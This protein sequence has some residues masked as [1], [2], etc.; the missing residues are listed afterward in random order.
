MTGASTKPRPHARRTSGAARPAGKR[1]RQGGSPV[2]G[3]TSRR[4]D[5][6]SASATSLG[7]RRGAF[8]GGP[9]RCGWVAL[10]GPPN[11]GKSTLLNAMLGQKVSIVTPRPQTTRNQIVGILTDPDAQIIFMDTPG[12]AQVR[13]R[14]SKAMVQ[15]AWQSLAQADAIVLLLDAELYIRKPEFLDNDTAALGEAL[16]Q[17]ERPLVVCVNKIDLFS[18]KSR[19]LPLLTRLHEMWPRAEIYPTSALTRDGLVE[20]VR[21]LKGLLP[22]G[23]A[24]FPEDQLSTAPVRFMAA[25]IV[26]EKLF[27]HLQQEVPYAVAVDIEAWEEDAQTG[28][29]LIHAAIH[30]A[31]PSHKAMVIG[32]GGAMIKEIGTE[33]RK[34]IEALLGCKVRLELWVK[35][36]EHWSE[37]VQFLQEMGLIQE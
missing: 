8:L 35:V 26:R 27:L 37:D 13:G 7:K 1:H 33:A 24:Q 12:M 10:M 22:E 21:L 14:L 4:E 28:H 2:R 20:F 32:R 30:V 23:P 6:H 16:A 25:E 19:M 3:D 36:R 17:E 18:D 11:A 5:S 29:T 31:R 34:D 15:A 9:H